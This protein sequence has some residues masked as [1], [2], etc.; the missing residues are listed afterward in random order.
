M[1]DQFLGER[2]CVFIIPRDE[3]PK[4]AELKAF[5]RERGLAAYKIPDRVEFVESFPQTGVGK[6]SKK[7]SVKPFPRSFLQDLKIK[8]QFE[9]KCSYGYTCHSAVS[10][11]D[12]I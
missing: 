12:S 5:L 7:R 10:N 6:V 2:S 11:A 3:A 9:R 8:Q 4:A 1:P